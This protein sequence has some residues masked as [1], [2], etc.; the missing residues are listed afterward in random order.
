VTDE[1]VD[2][3]QAGPKP[4]EPEPKAEANEPEPLPDD[5]ELV[6]GQGRL[7]SNGMLAADTARYLI[8]EWGLERF[9]TSAIHNAALGDVAHTMARADSR[10]D[11]RK[12]DLEPP[13]G[14][15]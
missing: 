9:R 1:Y 6:W 15:R 4:V 2:P 8:G 11:F 5:I 3:F 10:S 12:R 7:D 14:K 13:K